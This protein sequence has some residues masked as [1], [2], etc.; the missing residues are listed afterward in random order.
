MIKYH[1]LNYRE[2]IN[3][4]RKAMLLIE[5]IAEDTLMLITKENI[6]SLLLFHAEAIQ[7]INRL[8][9]KAIKNTTF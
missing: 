6:H 9:T 5:K 2:A 4:K 1:C 3:M 7:A 8:L